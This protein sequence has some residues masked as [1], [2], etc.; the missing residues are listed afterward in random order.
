MSKAHVPIV[1]IT[2]KIGG[3]GLVEN[4]NA[5]TR[6]KDIR[7]VEKIILRQWLDLY[8]GSSPHLYTSP[9]ENGWTRGGNSEMYDNEPIAIIGMSCRLPE[10]NNLDEFW[11]LLYEGREGIRP[12]PAYRWVKEHS[13]RV[14]P[15]SRNVC[16]GFLSCPIDEFDARFFGISPKDAA[17]MDPQSRLLHEVFWEGLENS[18][19]NPLSLHGSRTAIFTGKPRK[20]YNF[21]GK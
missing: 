6:Q 2:S 7:I 19:I 20:Q 17:F 4:I 11:K 1:R 12:P 5:L 21:Y 18:G 15:E 10:A 3:N 16:A 8:H 14:S 13:I 9:V